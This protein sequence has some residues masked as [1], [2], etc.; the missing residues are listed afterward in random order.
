MVLGDLAEP[1]RTHMGER[2]ITDGR[3]DMSAGL[4]PHFPK[5]FSFCPKTILRFVRGNVDK[6]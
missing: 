2:S 6:V 3:T 4:E 5:L 1:D